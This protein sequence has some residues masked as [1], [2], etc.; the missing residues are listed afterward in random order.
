MFFEAAEWGS[1]SGLYG[2]ATAL[3]LVPST[4]DTVIKLLTARK[5]EYRGD[6]TWIFAVF[7]P[8][9]QSWPPPARGEGPK[10][11]AQACSAACSGKGHSMLPASQKVSKLVLFVA[12]TWLQQ[13][14]PGRSVVAEASGSVP[15]SCMRRRGLSR[16]AQCAD[17]SIG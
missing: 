7:P 11:R 3:R 2:R 9:R 15:C 17:Q 14:I 10:M 8:N 4:K 6:A 5:Q 1:A 13:G 16:G 12:K